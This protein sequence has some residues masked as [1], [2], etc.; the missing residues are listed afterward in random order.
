MPHFNNYVIDQ[1]L[2]PSAALFFLIGSLAAVIVGIGLIVNS[3]AM[4][5][6]FGVMNRSVSTRRMSKSLEIQRDSSALVWKYRR[7]IAAF[8]MLGAAFSLYGLIAQIDNAAVV[9][10]LKLKYPP[11]AV[12]LVVECARW[13]LI[14]GC[15][16]ALAVGI[17]LRFFPDT[18]RGI[19][20]RGARWVS[21]RQM[22]SGVDTMNIALDDWVAAFPRVAGWA[23]LLPA[24]GM[25]LY[26]GAL[27]SGLR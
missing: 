19:E 27:L 4:M 3:A 9:A 12:L 6:L 15:A 17:L 26:F 5:R 1:L 24:L 8:F 23:I 22:A 25:T 13:L 18:L 11:A 14:V 20:A 21:T 7:P 10:A 16:A 2:I